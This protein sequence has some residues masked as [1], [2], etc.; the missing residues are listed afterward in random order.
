[1]DNTPLLQCRNI[2]SVVVFRALQLGDMLCAVPALRALRAALPQAHI[3]LVGLPWAGQF[4]ERFARYLDDFLPFPG[5]PDLPEQ[6]LREE[7]LAGFY[8]AVRFRRFTLAL[9][10]HGSGEISNGIV[11]RFG[12]RMTAGCVA[13]GMPGPDPGFIG[14]PYPA[15]GAEPLRLLDFMIKLGAPNRGSHLEFPLGRHDWDE[16]DASGYAAGLEPGRYIC[17]HP[18]ARSFDKCWPVRNFAYIADALAHEFGLA[19]VLTGSEKERA[20]AD[21][22]AAHMSAPAINAAGPISIGAMAALM[23]GARLLVCNDTGVSHIAAG[24][25]LNSVIIFS[26]ADMTRWSPLDLV[27]HRCV[28]DPAGAKTDEVLAEARQLLAGAETRRTVGRQVR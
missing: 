8:Q 5:H 27:L 25:G 1:M 17:L 4:V 7:E 3:T 18:G 19:V 20:L 26:K 16:L 6:P 15:N 2:A 9:Q 13:P 12:A 23:S 21:D 22:V 24:L 28:W 10:L 11:G 14:L